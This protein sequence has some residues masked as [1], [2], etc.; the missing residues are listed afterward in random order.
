MANKVSKD[1]NPTSEDLTSNKNNSLINLIEYI[2]QLFQIIYIV[3]PIL[4]KDE[5]YAKL[6]FY[7]PTHFE[8]LM[9]KGEVKLIIYIYI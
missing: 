3:E 1:Y 9:R 8:K 5:G 7:N 2:F 6:I 4:M